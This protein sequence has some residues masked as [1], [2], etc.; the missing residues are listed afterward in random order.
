MGRTT[1]KVNA[2]TRKMKATKRG[3]AILRRRQLNK[4]K[5]KTLMAKG[6]STLTVNNLANLLSATNFLKIA[7][8]QTMKRKVAKAKVAMPIPTRFSARRRGI[9]PEVIELP[10]RKR[11]SKLTAIPEAASYVPIHT[12][13]NIAPSKRS[14]SDINRNSNNNMGDFAKAFEKGAKL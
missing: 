12:A 7:N 9:A 2:F 8:S 14:G 6:P 3:R 1:R 11:T 5:G 4:R 10:G 13:A